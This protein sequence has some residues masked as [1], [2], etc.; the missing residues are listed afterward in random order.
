MYL[1]FLTELI[2][3]LTT[4]LPADKPADASQLITVS[5]LFEDAQP[6][7]AD[8]YEV[9]QQTG[10]PKGRGHFVTI[11]DAPSIPPERTLIVASVLSPVNCQS[12]HV[13]EMFDIVELISKELPVCTME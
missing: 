3:L 2:K 6:K 11:C 10:R 9:S 1:F 12:I 4:I 7:Y 13:D 8:C 5:P